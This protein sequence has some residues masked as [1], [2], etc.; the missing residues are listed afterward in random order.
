M[1]WGVTPAKSLLALL[2]ASALRR[3]IATEAELARNDGLSRENWPRQR[4][5]NSRPILAL[6]ERLSRAS[7]KQSAI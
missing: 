4:R 6:T 3:T 5:K 1:D 7:V 2:R